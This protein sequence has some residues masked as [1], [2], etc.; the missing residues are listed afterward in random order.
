MTRKNLAGIVN[1]DEL[2]VGITINVFDNDGGEIGEFQG[3]V[4]T[5]ETI[6]MI[7][8]DVAEYLSISEDDDIH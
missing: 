5:D 7:I 8:E 1:H 4:L 6:N 2:T 3:N